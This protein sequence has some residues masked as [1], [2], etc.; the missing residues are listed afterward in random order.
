MKTG[1]I[2]L[3]PNNRQPGMEIPVYFL[4]LTHIQPAACKAFP[5]QG[6]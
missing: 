2:S 5:V 3:M 4:K 1:K 6:A